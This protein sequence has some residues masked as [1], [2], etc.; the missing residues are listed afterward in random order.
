MRKHELRE[1]RLTTA[2][3]IG[4]AMTEAGDPAAPAVV[5]LHGGG[6]TR[7]AWS[8][9]V[10][11]LSGEGYHAVSVDL[12]GHGESDWSEHGD[13]EPDTFGRDLA[14][15]VEQLGKPAAVVGASMGGQAAIRAIAADCAGIMK[16][17]V[18]V[19]IVPRPARAGVRKVTKFMQSNL[20]G[21]ANL[22]E[23]ADAVAAYNPNR[24]RPRDTAGLLKNVRLRAD[25][26]YYWHWDPQILNMG[27][28]EEKLDA[29]ETGTVAAMSRVRVPSLLVRGGASDVV[30]N[31]VS[32]EF[33]RHIPDLEIKVVPGAGHMVAGDRNDA[34]NDAVIEFLARRHAPDSIRR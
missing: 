11:R 26:R 4:I 15:I 27:D 25:G 6:Q 33:R 13:Y 31:E 10:R 32:E 14:S 5:L 28:T 23:V 3:G 21:F 20:H 18:L 8:N 34:F 1:R 9:A 29:M 2:D 19:D 7:H 22:E 24:K 30:D 12:R 17:L 16:A